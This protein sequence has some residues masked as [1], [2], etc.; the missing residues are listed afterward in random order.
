MATRAAAKQAPSINKPPG[1]VKKATP[2]ALGAPCSD[3]ITQ[4]ARDGVQLYLGLL[5]ADLRLLLDGLVRRTAW[6]ASGMLDPLEL[7][8]EAATRPDRSEFVVRRNG[9]R[10][11]VSSWT[12]PVDHWVRCSMTLHLCAR[13]VPVRALIEGLSARK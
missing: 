7:R 12:V 10:V 1:Q 13:P 11:W 5:P 8:L 4:A 2:G 3:A 6:L 9:D